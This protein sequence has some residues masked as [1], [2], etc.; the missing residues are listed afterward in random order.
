MQ[1]THPTYL[2]IRPE[3]ALPDIERLAPFAAILVI[4]DDSDEMWRWD[5]ARWLVASGCRVLLAWGKECESWAESVDDALLE[6]FD[7]DDIPDDKHITTTWHEDEDLEEVFW[8]ARH[9]AKHPTLVLGTTL[10]LHIAERGRKDELE[11]LY[12]QA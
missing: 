2:H 1:K 9:R 3:G 6:A 11:A 4:D 7:Y 5:A 10:I 8:F 12:G